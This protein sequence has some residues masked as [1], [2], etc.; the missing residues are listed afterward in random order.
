MKLDNTAPRFDPVA[1]AADGR[2]KYRAFAGDVY[3][4]RV[5]AVRSPDLVD[6][7]VIVP[8]CEK[9]VHLTKIKFKKEGA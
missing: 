5:I 2:V 1:F 7:D 9:P 3:D 8:G 6:I 4:A